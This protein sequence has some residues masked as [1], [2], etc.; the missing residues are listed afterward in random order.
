MTERNSNERDPHAENVRKLADAMLRHTLVAGTVTT[1]LAVV[2]AA[3]TAGVTGL[4]GALIGAALALASA[5]ATLLIMR[6]VADLPPAYVRAV[7]LN[8]YMVKILTMF[9]VMAAMRLLDVASAVNT[10]ALAFALLAVV[11]AI[12]AAEV[13]AF[14]RTKIPTLVITDRD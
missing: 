5:V 6:L 8:G 14:T 2:V 12:A 10:T 9:V 4:F 7:V 1:V 3:M 11:V 13:R